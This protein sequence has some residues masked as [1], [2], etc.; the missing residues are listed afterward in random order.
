M[1]WTSA[2]WACNWSFSGAGDSARVGRRVAWFGGRSRGGSGGGERADLFERVE[3]V[4][5]PGPACGGV[6]RPGS[7]VAGEPAGDLEPAA[8]ERL[9]GADGLVGQTEQLRPAQ[10]VVGEGGEH[11][12]GAVCVELSRREVRQ[13][14]ILEVGDHLLDD[15]VLAVLALDQGD[16]LFAVGDEREVPPVGPELRLGAEEPGAADDQST[17]A[18]AGLGDLRLALLGVDDR[19]PG[20]SSIAS[21]AAR[22]P[23]CMRTPIEYCQPAC[24]SRL[25][26]LVF[27]KPESARSSLTP[28]APARPTRAIS[29]SVKRSI[30]FCVFADPV[31]RRMCSTSRVSARVA[32]SG[33]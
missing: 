15:G 11:G 9:G 17:A 19:L 13:R 27:Q 29:S 12:P 31:R 33:W 21:T 28:L 18:V 32:S 23:V 22:I 20:R 7:A 5:L 6:E 1:G 14:L 25:N 30:P 16:L 24:S 4:V 10:Q 26:T 8:A 2:G 3:V